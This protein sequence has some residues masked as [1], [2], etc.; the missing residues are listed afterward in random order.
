[1]TGT[2]VAVDAFEKFNSEAGF[3]KQAEP[4]IAGKSQGFDDDLI[5]SLENKVNTSVPKGVDTAPVNEGNDPDDLPEYWTPYKDLITGGFKVEEDKT[6]YSQ[7]AVQKFGENYSHLNSPEAV[8]DE[9]FRLEKGNEFLRSNPRFAEAQQALDNN[10]MPD[11]ELIRKVLRERMDSDP[12]TFSRRMYDERIAELFDE[13]NKL[14]EDGK[15]MANSFR[16]HYK[17]EYEK[18]LSDARS[19]A[20]TSLQAEKQYRNV[21]HQTLDTFSPMGVEIPEDMK[22]YLKQVVTRNMAN[23]PQPKTPEERAEYEIVKAIALDKKLFA[24]LLRGVDKRG[25]ETGKNSK[26]KSKI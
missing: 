9:S 17:N 19:H 23:P 14:T 12:I 11:A 6:N 8:Y 20:D 16:G 26:F 2:S 15:R 25:F 21:L 13:E 7:L 24:S 5:K 4:F 18:I 22:S 3:S 10:S 1:M